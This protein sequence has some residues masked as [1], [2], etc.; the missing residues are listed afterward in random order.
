MLLKIKLDKEEKYKFIP[1]YLNQKEIQE[2]FHHITNNMMNDYTQKMHVIYNK[3]VLLKLDE[4]YFNSIDPITLYL[5]EDSL[6]IKVFVE[7]RTFWV[8]SKYFE[9]I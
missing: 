1:T 2:Y 6:F 4:K 3:N 9:A 8:E 7:G 5:R